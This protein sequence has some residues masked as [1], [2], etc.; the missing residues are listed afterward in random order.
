MAWSPK[1]AFG[2]LVF[3]RYLALGIVNLFDDPLAGVNIAAAG[4][5]EAHPARQPLEQFRFKTRL[6][7]R[8]LA[9]DGRDRRSQPPGR[10]G[11]TARLGDGN[12]HGHCLQA[13][14]SAFQTL[15]SCF[16]LIL[17]A[18]RRGNR[19]AS[20]PIAVNNC[21]RTVTIARRQRNGEVYDDGQHDH[22]E[23]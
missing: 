9:A 6:E 12:Y 15:R 23:R 2:A 16:S 3:A 11:E 4:I 14:H 21:K 7:F 13:V 22:D 20:K 10:G 19:L 18:Y 17:A 1:I 5:G 8:D